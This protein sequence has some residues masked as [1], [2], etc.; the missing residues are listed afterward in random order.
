MVKDRTSCPS[1]FQSVGKDAKAGVLQGSGWKVPVVVSGLSQSKDG[2][3]EPS[4]DDGGGAE[5]VASDVSKKPSLECPTSCVIF[6]HF[7]PSAY[8][9]VVDSLEVRLIVGYRLNRHIGK[10]QGAWT[11]L[12]NRRD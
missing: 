8:F 10:P 4:G 2:R 7:R 5:G 1:V 12:T 3:G 9:G 11:T 6:T